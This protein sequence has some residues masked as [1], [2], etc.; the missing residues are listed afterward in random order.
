MNP[1]DRDC[2]GGE[3]YALRV[4]GHSMSPEFD[5]GDIVIVER[6]GALRDGCYVIA[7]LDDGFT[8]RQLVRDG[9]AWV[10]RA[11]NPA[12]TQRQSVALESV[13]GLVIQKSVPGRR[14]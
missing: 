14:R 2:S 1:A 8:L 4:I 11:L 12:F 13:H 7:R 3:P 10:L 9:E 5:E 6:D